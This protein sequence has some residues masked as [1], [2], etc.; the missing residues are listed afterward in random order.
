VALYRV[1]EGDDGGESVINVSGGLAALIS[2]H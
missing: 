1:R 2:A